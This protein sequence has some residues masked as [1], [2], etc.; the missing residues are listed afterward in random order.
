MRKSHLLGMG[1]II[2]I[3]IATIEAFVLLDAINTKNALT[4]EKNVLITDYAQL[5]TAY[6]EL[7]NSYLELQTAYNQLATTNSELLQSYSQL[8]TTHENLK[9]NHTDLQVLFNSLNATHNEL[10]TFYES[11]SQNYSILE[12]KFSN[13][14]LLY[15]L[16][17]EA[18]NE[19]SAN[20]DVLETLFKDLKAA[21]TTLNLT[22]VE[23]GEAYNELKAN[24]TTLQTEFTRLE[25]DYEL[26]SEFY[27]SY[28][29][30]YQK[31]RSTVNFYVL[32]PKEDDKK[33][34]TPDD[35]AV[36]AK[37]QEVTGGWSDPSDWGEFWA[38]VKKMYD[39]VVDYIEYR[40]DGLYPIL[41]LDP[42]LPVT[43]F[44]EMW[45]FPNQT[46]ALEKGDCDDMAILLA[47][48]IYSYG[49]KQYWVECIVITRHVAVYLPVAGDKIC[50]LDPA[51]QYYT[52]SGEYIDAKDTSTEV[53]AWLS[54]WD[55]WY[56]EHAPH[57]VKWVFSSHLY[58][59]FGNTQSFIDWMNGRA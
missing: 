9:S 4:Q 13:L 20:Y 6:D 34:I 50:I 29:F 54:K 46:L 53:N 22:Y 28:V 59:Y 56:P 32:H 27:A 40:S 8:Q 14:S 2:V 41:P 1:L 26:L 36:V 39:W 12:E 45:Q 25:T 48:M 7:D 57:V 10:T 33:F 3:S 44:G 49:G 23:L 5:N 55:S 16:L 15:S 47:S 18:Y 42:S 24:Y 58:K 19:L 43:L 52:K 38:D 17:N 21:Y 37:V 35:L 11:L 51:G 30:A 31:I